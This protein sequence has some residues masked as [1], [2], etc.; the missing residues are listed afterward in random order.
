MTNIDLRFSIDLSGVPPKYTIFSSVSFNLKYYNQF[1]SNF[2][3]KFRKLI[4]KKGRTLTKKELENILIYLDEHNIRSYNTIYNVNNWN[5]AYSLVPENKAYKKERLCGII[6]YLLLEKNTLQ[7]HSYS[8]TVCNEN[9]MKID[10]V[11][12]TCRI[13]SNMN[14]RDYNIS[15]SSDKYDFH[16]KI[17]DYVASATR[18]LKIEKLNE[19]KHYHLIKAQIPQKYIKKIFNKK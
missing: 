2:K 4:V 5:Y 8:V 7:N 19:F 15:I 10:H 14:K 13:L 3:N 17:A 6:Y 11:V 1:I 9:H 18:K 12:S 16:V